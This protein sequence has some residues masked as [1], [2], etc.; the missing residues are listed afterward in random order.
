MHATIFVAVLLSVFSVNALPTLLKPANGT[1]VGTTNGTS[2]TS[3]GAFNVSSVTSSLIASSTSAPPP[4]A[5]AESSLLRAMQSEISAVDPSGTAYTVFATTISSRPAVE[6]S[7]IGGPPGQ[8]MFVPTTSQRPRLVATATS[9]QAPTGTG[10]D[11]A[12]VAFTVPTSLPTG[13]AELSTVLSE[14]ASAGL[15]EATRE[16]NQASKTA[17]LTA[18]ITEVAGTPFVALSSISGPA[19]TLAATSGGKAFTTTFDGL[20]AT[21]IPGSN[22]AVGL[23]VSRSL[24]TGAVSVFGAMVAGAVMLL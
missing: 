9:Y 3:T 15:D 11:R 18:Y 14:L 24:L 17:E 2:S 1:S 12:N 10:S 22:S 21:A 4:F 7:A 13:G 19:I 8:I 23:S 20:S 16:I 6:I 5:S